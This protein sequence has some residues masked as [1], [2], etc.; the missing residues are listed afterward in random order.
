[1][2]LTA[3]GLLILGITGTYLWF[4]IYKERLAG[5]ILLAGGLAYGLTLVFLLGAN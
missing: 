2:F 1:M 3:V 5:S 4:K